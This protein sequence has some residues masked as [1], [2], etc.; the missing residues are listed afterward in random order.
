M[1]GVAARFTFTA[2]SRLY[3]LS[4]DEDGRALLTPSSA[5]AS[6]TGFASGP[7]PSTLNPEP[8]TLDP[9]PWTPETLTLNPNS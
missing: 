7:N 5:T 3:S 8:C 2:P 4:Q 9:E 1:R 6:T